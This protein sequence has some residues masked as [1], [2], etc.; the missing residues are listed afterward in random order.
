MMPLCPFLG[1]SVSISNI[2]DLADHPIIIAAIVVVGLLVF[3]VLSCAAACGPKSVRKK[4]MSL[5]TK[6]YSKASTAD[7]SQIGKKLEEE[8]ESSAKDLMETQMKKV[9]I[10]SVKL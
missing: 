9:G 2:S 1:Y 8:T 3:F 10:E 7:K 6:L 4:A 5:L